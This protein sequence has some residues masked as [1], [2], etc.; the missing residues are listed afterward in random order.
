MATRKEIESLLYYVLGEDNRQLLIKSGLEGVP[1]EAR[2][3]ALRGLQDLGWIGHGGFADFE[4]SYSL[5]KEGRRV[6]ACHPGAATFDRNVQE[7]VA[8]FRDVDGGSNGVRRDA[9]KRLISIQC[10]M[11]SW[12]SALLNCFELRKE[13]QRARETNGEAFAMFFQGRVEVAQNRWDEALESYLG[14]IERYMECGDR[15][16]VCLTNCA[17]GTVYGNKGDHASAI[18]CF[19]SCTSMAKAIGDPHTE[20]KAQGNLAIVYDLEGRTDESEKAS[21]SAL[22]YFMGIG[23]HEFSSRISNNLGVLNMSRDRFDAAAEY[24]EKT[25]LSCRLQ[26]N[27][28]V[29][30]AALVNAGYCHA[31][32]GDTDRALRYTDEAIRIFRE[33]HNMNMLA[34]AYRN[35]GCVEF[36]NLN[37]HKAF[38][39]FEK[40]VRSAQ[41]SGVEDTVAAC[42]YE[43]GV[44]LIKSTADPRLAKKLLKK[45]SSVYREIGNTA[46]ARLAETTM[47]SI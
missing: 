9:L 5:T 11:G 2:I 1:K 35:Y 8:A 24:F 17:M 19:E 37:L 36:R 13:S 30:G 20:A 32:T 3:A 39:W 25:I 46:R 44:A 16:G 31:R 47:A 26:H 34:L 38:E 33:P 22:A 21:K 23:D 28:E 29:L 41:S 6:V 4:E 7:F 40:S 12:D 14:A 18:R 45:S 43:Y 42:C 27:L 15:K 10:E